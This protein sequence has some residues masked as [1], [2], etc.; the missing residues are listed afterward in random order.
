MTYK[1]L[2]THKEALDALRFGLNY[3]QDVILN[4]YNIYRD[5]YLVDV[6]DGGWYSNI[7]MDGAFV[8]S[9]HKWTGQKS[10][11]KK[12][13]QDDYDQLFK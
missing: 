12:A 3:P 13:D 1:D 10:W 5:I 4:K 11:W 9:C 8:R 7:K 6:F 2:L